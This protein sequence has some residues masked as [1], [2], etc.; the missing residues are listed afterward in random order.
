MAGSSKARR[1]PGLVVKFLAM[2]YF[3]LEVIARNIIARNIIAVQVFARNVIAR[4]VIAVQVFERGIA[5]S[6]LA[7]Q[8]DRQPDVALGSA[9][10]H[11]SSRTRWVLLSQERPGG[12][13]ALTRNDLGRQTIV[14]PDANRLPFRRRLTRSD[15]LRLAT[16]RSGSGGK[17]P[18][19]VAGPFLEFLVGCMVATGSLIIGSGGGLRIERSASD[20]RLIQGFKD[21]IDRRRRCNGSQSVAATGVT[22]ISAPSTRRTQLGALAADRLATR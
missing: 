3:A 17:V 8:R 1:H 12:G 10:R 22:I 19:C 4:N 20:G 18:R 9:T 16:T 21:G 14:S 11:R 13:I 6:G 15:S 7:R 2:R 5:P